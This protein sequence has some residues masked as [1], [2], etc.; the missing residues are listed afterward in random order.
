MGMRLLAALAIGLA[1]AGTVLG[2]AATNVVPDS[3]AGDGSGN[4]TG[5]TV[6]NITYTLNSANPQQV[7]KVSFQL[8]PSGAQTVKA[9]V[10]N[11]S[12][13]ASCSLSGSTWTC[14]F[15]PDAAVQPITSLRVV[16]AQ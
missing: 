1:I 6:S 3:S 11:G 8:S 15:T 12:T 16:A 5:Y 7:D 14:D 4:V 10:D 13:W 9:S 2:L